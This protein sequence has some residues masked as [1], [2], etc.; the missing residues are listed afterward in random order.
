[1]FNQDEFDAKF[2]SDPQAVQDFFSKADTGF[3]A[4][5]GKLVDSLAGKNSS[6]LDEENSALAQKISDNQARITFMNARLTAQENQL[7][8][9]FY[10]ME[11][12]V[13]KLQSQQS[14]ISQIQYI[15]PVDSSTSSSS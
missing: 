1:M 2:D 4:Q 5:F 6:M 8:T 15:A 10:N 7:Y 9:Q 14:A 11:V 12:A 3:S 13:S